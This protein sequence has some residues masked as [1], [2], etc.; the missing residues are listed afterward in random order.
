MIDKTRTIILG[1]DDNDVCR[2]ALSRILRQAGFT[3]REAATDE[4]VLRLA[5][6]SPA[7][8]ILDADRPRLRVSQA[9]AALGEREVWYRTLFDSVPVGLYRTTPAGQILDA[10]PALVQM[11]GYPDRESLLAVNAA[12]IYANP[13]DR[14]RQAALLEREGV[15]DCEVQ[16]RRYDGATIWVRDTARAVR[17]ARGQVLYYDGSLE[18]ITERKRAEEALR[19][20][21]ASYRELAD[22][23]ADIF[24]AFDKDL[25]YTYWN[26]AAEK[27]TGI[28][29]EDALGKSLYELFPDTPETRRAE[30]V[31]RDV[32]RTQQPQ[33][34]VNEYQ[35]GGKTY[36]FEISAYPSKRGLS[37]FVK[38]ITERKQAEAEVIRLSNAM[39]MSTDSIVISDLEGRIIDVNEATLKMYGADDKRDLIGKSAFDLIAPEDR[40]KALAGAAETLETGHIEGWEYHIITK[41]GTRTLVEMSVA[42]LQDGAGNPIGFVGVNRDIT[43][44]YR[45]EEAL[46]QWAHIFEHAEWG[47]VVGSADGQRAEMMNP[48]F[49]RMHG[50]TVEELTGKPIVDLVAPEYREGFPERVGVATEKGH[51][52]FESKR[53]RKDG[54]SFPALVDV[55]VVKDEAGR[56]LYRVVNVQDITE[57]KRA[58]EQIK[59]ALAEKEVLLR[60]VHHRVK[61]NL[62]AIIALLSMQAEQIGDAR[63]TQSLQELQERA[64]TMALVYEHLCQAESLAQIPM[65]LY[66]QDLSDHVFQS[67]SGGRAIKLSV[68]ATPVSLDVETA[69]PCGLIVNELLTNALKY[70]FPGDSQAAAG[71]RVEFR[72]EDATYTLVVSDNGVGLPPGLDWRKPMTM[73][74]RLVNF[75]A[76]HQLGGKLE[77]NDQ[78]GTAFKVTF[79]GRG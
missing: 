35:L 73:G 65:Q 11:L 70:A 27:L 55:T 17:D 58:E 50:Y 69:M 53:L 37:V 5:A 46:R 18:D 25:R 61:N 57:R 59:A 40:E 54:T 38:D 23:I 9:E 14:W 12:D 29:A 24:F 34:L 64:Y 28:P 6:E 16:L 39:R 67:F 36:F 22:S 21:E 63:T 30:R 56:V 3:V 62:Q 42:I 52:A 47:V 41:S 71:V 68:E 13:Q 15:R 19:E 49:A 78:Q 72:A 33:S 1:V 60:E 75:W 7:L 8:V 32:L 10:N 26:Q 45:A 79:V 51:Y 20:S 74:L 4:E 66:L 44:R 76:T 2:H 48:A 43:E 77:V 31:Y